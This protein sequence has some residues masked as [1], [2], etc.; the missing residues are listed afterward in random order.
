MHNT[1]PKPLR[2]PVVNGQTL[3]ADFDGGAMSSDFGALLISG[4]NR[5]TGLVARL[6]GAI[7][8]PRHPAYTTH[9]IE[10][11]LAQRIFQSAC[12]YED[13]N[14]ANTLRHDPMFKLALA[15]SGDEALASNPTFSRF[16]NSLSTKDMYRMAHAFV[17]AFIASYAD[18]PASIILDMDHAEDITHGQQPL[19]LFNGYYRSRCYLPLFLFEGLSGKFICAILRPGQR[20]TG[21]ENAAILS[22]II[23]KLRQAWPDTH[24]LLRGDGHF[25]NSELMALCDNDE[26]LDFVFGLTG[27]RVL[28]PLAQPHLNQAKQVHRTRTLHAQHH[29]QPK[30]TS[31]KVYEDLDYQAGSWSN[32][33]RVVVKAEV[34]ALG[35]NPRFIVSSLTQ[36]SAQALYEDFYCPRGQDE[37]YIKA[38]KNDL[39][40]DRTT[41]H[42]FIANQMRVFYACAAYSLIHA[43]REHTLQGTELAKAQ[44]KTLMLKLFKIAVRVR[45]YKDRIKLQLPS[46]VP[47]QTILHR[48]CELLY[49]S[50]P[51]QPA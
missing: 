22:R 45:Q 17:E 14:D 21:A 41:C 43:L 18:A 9:R 15:K 11:L 4:V 16:E 36:P 50:K 46:H 12:G 34:M 3:R 48:V 24:M 7:K 19:A 31:T 39:A 25:T 47:M 5:Q 20:P 2:F 38:L 13:G 23:K 44:P 37:N 42:S 27:N 32:T 26:A 28:S 35:E 8:D 6:T 10:D 40:V 49:L 51:P 1:N 29:H 33:Y 30:P